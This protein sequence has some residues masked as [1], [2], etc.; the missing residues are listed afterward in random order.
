MPTAA[1][2]RAGSVV[3]QA[4]T[5]YAGTGSRGR[6]M[7][8]A[9]QHSQYGVSTYA[10]SQGVVSGGYAS[11]NSRATSSRDVSPS[12][13]PA[14]GATFELYSSEV[15]K[16]EE[17]VFGPS[18]GSGGSAQVYRGSW[19]G[20]E[21]AIKKI[22]GLSH[23]AEMTKE[24]NALRRLRHP[25]LVSFIG[26]CI[27]PPI[28]VVVTEFMSGGSLHDRLFGARRSPGLTGAQRCTIAVQIVEGLAFLHQNRVV[29]RDMKSMNILIDAAGH[30][31]L[32]DFGLAQ[33]MEATHI[34]RKSDGE[35][36]SPRYMAPECYDPSLA[37]LT[38]KVDIWA[39]GCVLI[40]L[41]GGILAYA[42]CTTMVH[43]TKRITVDKRP[44]DVPPSVNPQ[45]AAVIRN[46]VNFDAPRRPNASDLLAEISR[47]RAA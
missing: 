8:P 19:K 45:V 13:A 42:D 3:I 18:L 38:E 6:S 17:L 21:V 41:F 5:A 11:R 33:Q 10:S 16:P 34:E 36:G 37:K 25:R 22:S 30:A 27:Q 15:V 29:H 4:P 12:L 23:L 20:K 24:I 1:G 2:S 40:E 46:C 43:L 7:S 44:P 26:A 28:L 39:L 31:K 14:S 32:C 35:G 9:V 47:F